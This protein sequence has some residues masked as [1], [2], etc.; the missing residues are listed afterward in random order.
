MRAVPGAPSSDPRITLD[1]QKLAERLSK[2]SGAEFDREYMA[3]MVNGHQEALTFFE[4]ESS[5]AAES[6]PE[7]AQVSNDLLP[8]VRQ[9]LQKAI[10][11]QKTLAPQ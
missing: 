2:V 1:D 11:I 9:H 3:A 4:K 6:L 5:I 8:A 7:L 10:E